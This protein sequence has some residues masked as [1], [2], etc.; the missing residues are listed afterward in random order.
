MKKNKIKLSIIL[1]CLLGLVLFLGISSPAFAFSIGSKFNT[2]PNH[3]KI[4]EEVLTDF[5]VKVGDETFKFARSKYEAYDSINQ[6]VKANKET[7]DPQKQFNNP[8]LHFDA[9]DFLGG[10]ERVI[11]LKEEII[12]SV[13]EES[14]GFSA[15]GK[16]GTALHT[17]QDF[18]AHS[19][20]VELGHS[21]SEINTDIGRK[22]FS[23]VDKNTSTC[24]NDPGTLGGA[25]LTELTS[26]YFEFDKKLKFVPSCNFPPGK[27]R[28][29]LKLGGCPDGLNKDDKSR[30][31]FKTA[32][33]L[34]VH[35]TQDFLD[36]I[37][38]DPRMDGNVDAIKVLMR[39]ND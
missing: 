10:S 3:E 23:G 39:I 1:S 6:I 34:A 32:R 19:N 28:H 20:W 37:F 7:D 26:G 24:P 11:E 15:R 14:N 8:E 16:L 4:T 13:T 18:Y 12:R 31:G 21:G 22:K 29:G 30:P 5:Q 2:D 9:E 27:C 35:A 33:A 25:G 36:Q 38:S 17:V